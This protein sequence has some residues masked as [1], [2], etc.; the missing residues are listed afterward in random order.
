MFRNA[1]AFTAVSMVLGTACALPSTMHAQNA[2]VAPAIC[3]G[4]WSTP[5]PVRRDDGR[6]VYV[7]RG[8]IA[9]F[10]G[11]TL[12]LGSPSFFWLGRSEMVPP[13]SLA[14]DTAAVV[15]SLTGA[16]ALING[17]G[18]AVA[19]PPL[20]SL[21]YRRTPRLI[22]EDDHAIVVAWAVADSASRSPGA[23]DNRVDVASFDGKRWS[24]PRTIIAAPHLTLEP[25]PAMRAGRRLSTPMITATGRDSAGAFVRVARGD[26]TNWI[27]ADWRDNVFTIG[28][29]VA[30]AWADG[31]VTLVVMGSLLKLGPG[32]FSIRGEPNGTGYRWAA[33]QLLDSLRDSYQPFSSARLEGDSLVVVWYGPRAR[34]EDG[35]L[36]TALSIDRGRSWKLTTPL[37]PNSS[38]DGEQ[39]A[40][41][42]RGGLHVIFRGAGE[43]HGLNAPGLIVHSAWQRG[44][45][46]RPTAVS[47]EASLVSPAIGASVGGGLMATW[48]IGDVS[49]QGIAPKS[50]A[51]VWTPGCVRHP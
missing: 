45:W 24:T 43:D 2:R 9:P 34:G 10:A 42:A 19:V 5:F 1:R 28:S 3:T 36:N 50:F 13:D 32:I 23:N 6:P 18:I 15:R 14:A 25:A 16:G 48:A 49:S 44:E 29:A 35:V 40:V 38:M 11:Q 22:A 31:S 21:R 46:T 20:D 17:A 39:L 41:D 51:S 47:A 26:G 4:Q 30:S 37:A 27:T 33:P 8:V 7:E 12:A